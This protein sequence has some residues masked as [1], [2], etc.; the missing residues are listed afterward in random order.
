MHAA[1][2]GIAAEWASVADPDTGLSRHIGVGNNKASITPEEMATALLN[3]RATITGNPY[4]Q[5]LAA[6]AAQYNSTTNNSAPTLQQQ[7]N[8]TVNGA[9]D[10]DSTAKAVKAAQDSAYARALRNMQ[11]AVIPTAG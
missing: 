5:Q 4:G 8:I 7:T 6:Q 1:L 11:S 9:N 3:T 10:P 2:K